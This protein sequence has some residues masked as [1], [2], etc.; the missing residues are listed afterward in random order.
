MKQ[1]AASLQD[2]FKT[3]AQKIKAVCSN[4]F[5]KY[6]TDLAELKIKISNLM[7]KYQDWQKVLIEPATV[8]D[9][10]LFSVESRLEEEEEMRIREYEYMRDL[11]KKLF[12]SLEQMNMQQIDQKG[13]ANTNHL[14]LQSEMSTTKAD[15]LPNLLN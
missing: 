2:R 9:A 15:R 8:N 1:E 13:M 12:Y 10:R 5:G 3:N 7:D 6:E 11:L 14:N 4:Y